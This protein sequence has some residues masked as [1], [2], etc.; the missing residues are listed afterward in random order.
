MENSSLSN[1]YLFMSFD[2]L[3]DSLGYSRWISVIA[4]LV[5]PTISLIG[6]IPCIISA[7][8]FFQSKFKE[9]V[10]FYYR[11]LCLIYIFNLIHAMPYG[12]LFSPRT[13]LHTYISSLFF[14]Y[15]TI[16]NAILLNFEDTLKMGILLDRMKIF[17]PFV[18]KYFSAK[19]QIITVAFF[20]T[21]FAINFPLTFGLK[22][23]RLYFSTNSNQTKNDTLYFITSSEFS[24]TPFG[25]IFLGFTSFF[26]NYFL[27]LNVGI[28]LNIVPVYQYKVY[29]RQ[30]KQRDRENYA[31]AHNVSGEMTRR[32]LTPKEKMDRIAEK[33]MFNMAF[34]L[35][36]ISIF[37]RSLLMISYIYWYFFSGNYVLIPFILYTFYTC[38]P[39]VAI[40]AF[41]SFNK[42]FREEFDIKILRRFKSLTP[43]T[44]L[45]SNNSTSTQR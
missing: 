9:P 41:Y 28:I 3:L 33:N 24:L 4:T 43:L 21:S 45:S 12:I 39:S 26:L 15:Y 5:L 44:S 30:R 31:T 1:Q 17:S 36:L 7:Y 13:F 38:V 40:F 29:L 27:T 16:L 23:D 22:I 20:L 34:T 8:I 2:Q 32:E 10:F 35:C 6:I 11:I 14:L 19:P 18:R 42:M 25:Q 37:S